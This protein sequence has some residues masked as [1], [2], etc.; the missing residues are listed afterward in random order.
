MIQNHGTLTHA[1]ALVAGAARPVGRAIADHFGRNAAALVLPVHSDWPESN[2]DMHDRFTEAGY[3]FLSCPCDLTKKDD[4][5]NLVAAAVRTYGSIN[6]LINN[7]ER[8]GMPIV[9]GPYDLPVNETQWELEF[10]TSV[11]AKWNLYRACIDNMKASGYGA[12]VNI[13][14]IAAEV[15]RT[16]PASVLFSDGYSAANRAISS[17]TRQWAREASPDIRV[18][19]LMIGL[20]EGRHGEGTR[21]W[22]LM[23]DD[24]RGALIDHTLLGRA[25]TP[26]EIAET[27]Y[28]LAV[29]ATYMTGSVIVC[30]GGYLLGGEDVEPFPRGNLDQS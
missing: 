8:G 11:K 21:G 23:S 26:E 17:F 1:V 25:T 15:G 13:S 24:Q 10:E 2:A 12:V 28:F 9:H 18:N 29:Y 22:G 14:S 16:G 3:D 4:V 7:I 6:Y 19:E 20:C 27:V 5:E 30:D